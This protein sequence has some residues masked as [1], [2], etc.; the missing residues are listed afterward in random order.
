MKPMFTAMKNS[1]NWYF[2]DLDKKIP[3]DRM[4][5]YLQQ[6]SYGNRDLS[7]G[8]ARY[9]QE[10]SLKISSVEQVQLL[11]AF[12]TNQF[13][14]Q[15]KNIATVKEAIH[16][17]EKSGSRLSGKTGT[18]AVNNKDINGWFIGY[19]ETKEDTY[20]FATNIQNGDHSNGSTAA[21]ITLSILRDKGIY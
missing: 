21:E 3:R 13:G 15:E 17:D 20:F 11:K 16:L 1:V 4:Q 18:G 12:Y 10:S 5:A 2:E 7:G 19:V 14:F 6:T 9:W 8:I